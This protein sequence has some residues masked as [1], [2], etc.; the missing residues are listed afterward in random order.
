MAID[1]GVFRRTQVVLLQSDFVLSRALADSSAANLPAVER[2]GAD[3][4]KWLKQVVSA[5][6]PEGASVLRLQ[7]ASD[8]LN[9]EEAKVLAQAIDKA[10][11]AE[12]IYRQRAER[13]RPRDILVRTR[14]KLEQ[15]IQR[16]SERL[17]A[18]R[19][20]FDKPGETKTRLLVAQVG[21]LEAEVLRLED[22]LMQLAIE[23]ATTRATDDDFRRAA[24]QR[25]ATRIEELRGRI[26]DLTSLAV[27]ADEVVTDLK[28]REAEIGALDAIAT[29]LRTRAEELEVDA[30]RPDR[31]T[32]VP[33]VESF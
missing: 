32:R 3:A 28:R 21:R 2:A 19:L 10:Y 18:L 14:M 29:R 13:L 12:V 20:D 17:E 9:A 4:L 27:R 5:E 25:I 1:D 31:V 22:R 24:E 26:N 7:V 8:E 30:M 23:A 11:T 33:G 15:E 16:K 6:I